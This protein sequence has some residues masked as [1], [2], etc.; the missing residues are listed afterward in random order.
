MLL[1]FFFLCRFINKYINVMNSVIPNTSIGV[2]VP[3]DRITTIY[4]IPNKA[5]NI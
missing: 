2:L 3:I 4:N 1:Y 5:L